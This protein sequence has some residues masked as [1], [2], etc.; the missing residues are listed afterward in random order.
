MLIR[1]DFLVAVVAL[2]FEQG[3]LRLVATL[4]ASFN[5]GLL[6][7][8]AACDGGANSSWEAIIDFSQT[9]LAMLLRL[10]GSADTAGVC[11]KEL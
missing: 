11:E 6:R 5:Q 1:S 7:L 2:S 8:V 3:L 9:F 4:F 10:V